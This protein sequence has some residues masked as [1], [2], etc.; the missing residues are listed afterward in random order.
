MVKGITKKPCKLNIKL[1]KGEFVNLE[2]FL[3][4]MRDYINQHKE[5]IIKQKLDTLL[6]FIKFR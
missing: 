6:N 3:E 2:M 1:Y 5:E 4:V